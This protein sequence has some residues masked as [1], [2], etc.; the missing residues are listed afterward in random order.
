MFN[1]DIQRYNLKIFKKKT[2]YNILKFQ[3]GRQNSRFEGALQLNYQ[4]KI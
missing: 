1:H 2:L 4:R 3:D